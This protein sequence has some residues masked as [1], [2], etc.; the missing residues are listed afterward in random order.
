MALNQS[1]LNE[2]LDALRAGGDWTSSA[3]GWRWC[4]KP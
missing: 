2:L 4:S 3:K 1:A